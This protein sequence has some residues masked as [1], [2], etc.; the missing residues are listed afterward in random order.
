M[1]RFKVE[2]YVGEGRHKHRWRAVAANGEIVAQ[3]EGYTTRRAMG[4]TLRLIADPTYQ[5]SVTV[6]L[7]VAS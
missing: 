7:A 1:R 3:G 4:K 2:T 5:G 6:T